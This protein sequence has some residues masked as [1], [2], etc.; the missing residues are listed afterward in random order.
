ML[1]K[2]VT[3]FFQD[4]MLNCCKCFQTQKNYQSQSHI[5]KL[6]I[7]AWHEWI[8]RW[9]GSLLM[10]FW[11]AWP[12]TQIWI[13]GSQNLQIFPWVYSQRS[14]SYS[15]SHYTLLGFCEAIY[16]CWLFNWKIIN[17]WKLNWNRRSENLKNLYPP[18]EA[19]AHFFKSTCYYCKYHDAKQLYT[20]ICLK[21]ID[22]LTS[23]FANLLQQVHGFRF[24]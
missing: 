11:H 6:G 7:K 20:T 5:C 8:H 9:S 17:I 12:H 23:Y 10:S 19:T 13:Y 4:E 24:S 3:I 15:H 14:M 1:T 16:K 21:G 2:I 18:Y 22:H